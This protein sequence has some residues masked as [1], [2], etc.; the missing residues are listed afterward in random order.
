MRELH[1]GLAG[2]QDRPAATD[3][4]L[5]DTLIIHFSPLVW[6]DSFSG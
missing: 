6:R 1:V 2:Q 3:Q 4:R 5:G